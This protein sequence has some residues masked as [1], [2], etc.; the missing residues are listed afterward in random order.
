MEK[1][2]VNLS[3]KNNIFIVDASEFLEILKGR[4]RIYFEIA[5]GLKI[6]SGE[7]NYIL[8]EENSFFDIIPEVID[9]LKNNKTELALDKEVATLIKNYHSEQKLFNEAKNLGIKIKRNPVKQIKIPSLTRV[10]KPYQVNPVIHMCSLKHCANFSVPGSGKTTIVYSVFDIL[11]E[12]KEITK[13]FIIGPRSC[14][15]PWEDEYK[16]CFGR[17]PVSVRLTGS[18]RARLAIYFRWKEF[19]IFLCTYQTACN[20]ID[21]IISTLKKDNFFLV[22]DESHYIKRFEGGVWAE[23]TLKIAPYAKKRAILTGTPMP[24][25]LKD[26]WTQLN[27]L[28]PANEI[29]GNKESYYYFCESENNLQLVQKKIEPFFTRI[30]KSDLGL[31]PQ[32]FKRILVKPN[33]LQ[34]K[35]Y[36]ALAVKFLKEIDVSF[37]ERKELREWRKARIVRLIQAASNPATLAKHS[38]EFDIP[39]FKPTETSLL[40]IIQ[41]YPKYEVPAKIKHAITLANKLLKSGEKVIIWSSFVHNIKMLSN[42]IKEIK[43][44]IIYGAIPKDESENVEFNREQQ[45]REFKEKKTPSILLA[46]PAACAESISLHKVCHHSIYLDRTFNCGQYMQS[47]DRIHRVGLKRNENVYYHILICSNTIDETIDRRLLEKQDSM[48][49]ILEEKS[50]PLGSLDVEPMQL[51]RDEDEEMQDL[52]AVIEDL[53]RHVASEI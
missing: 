53:K 51:G 17:N 9:Y 18:K 15:Q 20:D 24:N 47:L 23:T 6:K 11:K 28:W 42:L 43:P 34:Q 46:N 25:N 48:N 29:L 35:I 37:E 14:F 12:K 50:V 3:I 44:F 19:E 2:R 31:P 13:L 32:K 4:H 52:I 49:Y 7:T 8:E 10:L 1:G 41:L 39:A 27:F 45:I 40:K 16:L 33:K 22:L 36:N 26:L 21:R 5:L 30:P 38:E